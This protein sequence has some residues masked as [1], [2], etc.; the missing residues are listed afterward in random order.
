M[1]RGLVLEGGAM[2]GLFSAGVIDTMMEH[3]LHPDG[4]VGV[5]A[6]A[7]FGCNYKSGQLGRAIRYNKRFA[8]DPEYCSLSSLLKTGDLF[9]ARFA[10]HVVPNQ[11]DV[12][13][14]EAFERSQMDY[15]VVCTDVNTGAP[16]Y[17]KCDKGGDGFFEWVRASASMPL[18]A[19][20][21]EI[22]GL[23]LLDGGVSD[24][25][26]LKFMDESGYDA[27]VVVLT[28]PDGYVKHKSRLMPLMRLWLRKY[29][30]FCNAMAHRHVMYNRQLAY[31]RDA[32]RCGRCVVIRPE[33]PLPIGHISH[34][35]EEMQQVYNLGKSV[36]AKF[37]PAIKELWHQ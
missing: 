20:P 7:A 18:A 3:G 19:K 30:N 5:S 15:Y 24:S 31:V 33:M 29:P 12:F 16:V 36:A 23:T 14:S 10:Y 27:N 35:P 2:R 21:V 25:I 11:Y 26:P 34:N 1:K 37:I 6:G 22:D 17:H 13:D 4:I 32:E 9:N 8:R 28:Q